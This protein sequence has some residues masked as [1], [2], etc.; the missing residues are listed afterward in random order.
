MQQRGIDNVIVLGVHLNMCVLGRPFSIRQMVSQGKNVFL[1]RD[2]TDTMYNSRARPFVP[3]AIGTELMLE[4]VERYW[5]PTIS[6]VG[7]LGGNEFRFSEDQRPTV[8]FLIGDEEYRTGETVLEWAKNELAWRGV[9]TTFVI[10]DP[11]Q[12]PTFVGLEKLSEADAL[13]L[14]LKRRSLSA[15]QMAL[16][17]NFFASG[18]PLV[19]IRTASHAFGAREVEP[20]RIA[21]DTFDRDVLGGQYQNHYGKGPPT[22]ASIPSNMSSHA[23]ATGLPTNGMRFAS[24][25]YKCRDLAPTTQV[26]LNG[27]LED[28]PEIVEP[29]AWIN[30]NASRRVF[31]TSLGSPEDFQQPAFR[32]LLLNSVLWALER[33]APPANA[34]LARP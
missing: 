28:K 7:F 29:I 31:Y 11:K 8:L 3:H 6:S 14:S 10:D 4:H 18:K 27:R 24:H 15:G 17:T 23:I 5:C 19:A 16:L 30:T 1:M 32:R 9:R 26:I 25:L 22:M 33:S 34:V 20:G 13:F 21:W 12:P 2:M